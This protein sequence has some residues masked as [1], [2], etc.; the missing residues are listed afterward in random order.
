M[1]TINTIYTVEQTFILLQLPPDESVPAWLYNAKLYFISRSPAELSLVCPEILLPSAL[2]IHWKVARHWNI[3]H[4]PPL[5]L[6]L[7]GITAR[8][9]AI[10]AEQHINLNVIATFDTDYIMIPSDK[11]YLAL[12]ALQQNGYTVQPSEFT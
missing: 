8:L 7:T 1:N 12:H 3:I 10:L 4:L 11:F 5:D 9:S 6:S 2:P